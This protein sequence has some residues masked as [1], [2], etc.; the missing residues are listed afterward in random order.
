[1]INDE[2][3]VYFLMAAILLAC[4]ALVYAF[5]LFQNIK[6]EKI[7]M[8]M[9]DKLSGFIHE[10]A[11]AF[12][13]REYRVIIIFVIVIAVL[14]ASLGFIP[15][16]Q[17]VDGV[18]MGAAFCFIIGTLCS[19]VAGFCGMQAATKANAR[20]SQAAHDKGMPKALRIAF[21]GGSVLGLCVVGFGLLGLTVLFLGFYLFSH[22]YALSAHVVS[23]YSLGCSMIALFARVGGGIYTKAAD[24]GADLVGKVESGIPEDDPRNPAVIADNVGDNVGDIAGMGSDL[25]ESYVGAIVSAISLGIVLTVSGKS[26][27]IAGSVFPIMVCALGII[28]SIAAHQKILN[29]KSLKHI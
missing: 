17:N 13:G 4:L 27:G 15:A 1:M 14:L 28:A 22:N 10:G 16:L 11:M 7:H 24:V 9:L 18:G 23:G 3:A 8:R 29:Y 12:L 25:C 5:F 6:R 26:V 21:S 20:V 19:G 2:N